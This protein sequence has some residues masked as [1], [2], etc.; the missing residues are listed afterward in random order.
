ML[1]R[2]HHI[3]LI[4]GFA[5]NQTA[6]KTASTLTAASNYVTATNISIGGSGGAYI[7]GGRAMNTDVA[8]G[9]SDIFARNNYVNLTNVA[10]SNSAA[11]PSTDGVLQVATPLQI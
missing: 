7:F 1:V 11:D 10:V 5:L 2:I 6:D 3:V 8:N 9:S 4:G